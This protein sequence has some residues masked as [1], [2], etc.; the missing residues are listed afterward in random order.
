[1]NNF[2]VKKMKNITDFCTELEED[3]KHS[4]E[5]SVTMDEAEKLAAKFLYAQI[6]V[7]NELSRTDLDA[8]MKKTGVKA[9]KAAI[10]MQEATKSDKK[11]SD[12]MLNAIIDMNHLV[13]GEQ[14]HLDEVEIERNS[15]EN[16]LSIFHEAHIYFRGVAKGRF[17]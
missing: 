12:V 14:N 1:M 2:I 16:Y 15:L 7:A 17:E 8:K 9:I 3:I 13:I 5:S 4:Y 6:K 10:Y 11:P